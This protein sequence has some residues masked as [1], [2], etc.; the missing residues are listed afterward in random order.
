MSTLHSTSANL[1]DGRKKGGEGGGS[2]GVERVIML[3]GKSGG[4]KGKIG[5]REEGG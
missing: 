5:K 3:R 2:V 4:W 1:V